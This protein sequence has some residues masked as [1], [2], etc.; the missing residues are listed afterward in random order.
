MS[1][2]PIDSVLMGREQEAGTYDGPPAAMRWHPWREQREVEECGAAVSEWA[3]LATRYPAVVVFCRDLG[4]EQMDILEE[5]QRAAET[6]A[7]ADAVHEFRHP[8]TEERTG[9]W[10]RVRDIPDDRR[11]RLGWL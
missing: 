10:A 5:V 4:W 2:D 7:P 3:R 8:L 11:R 6:G 9:R 1:Y